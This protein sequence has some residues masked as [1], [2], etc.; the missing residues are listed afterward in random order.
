MA[1]FLIKVFHLIYFLLAFGYSCLGQT[2]LKGFILSS[3]DSSAVQSAA[4]I[5]KI[6]GH[7]FALSETDGYFVII[8]K[9]GDL[10]EISNLGYENRRIM[11]TADA[12]NRPLQ[13][14]LL[15]KEYRLPEVE[16]YGRSYKK[17]SLALRDEFK[18]GFDFNVPS[19][20]EIIGAGL[21]GGGISIDAIYQ[22]MQFKR[23]KRW[24]KFRLDLE[25]KEQ[26]K[27]IAHR[28][29]EE[30]I[31][32]LTGLQGSRLDSFMEIYKPHYEWLRIASD[33]DLYEYIKRCSLLETTY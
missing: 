16:I 4:L 32:D 18:K 26:N 8:A 23:N 24:E 25:E 3:S 31:S 13:I 20:G 1:S 6:N 33:Y 28:F 9:P 12:L 10:I 15:P 27:Y 2:Y 22:A 7:Q 17:D 19:A 11:V 14:F 21:M 5:N 30:I 29:N